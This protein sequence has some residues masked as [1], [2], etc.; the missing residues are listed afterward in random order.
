MSQRY[1][2]QNLLRVSLGRRLFAMFYDSLIILSIWL[3]ITSVYHAVVHCWIQKLT[4]PPIG[5]DPWLASILFMSTFFYMACYW[6]K[7]GQTLGMQAWKI[8]IQHQNGDLLN[9]FQCL[10]RFM[11]SLVSLGIMGLGFFWILWTVERQSWHDQWTQSEVVLL[12]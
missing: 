3:I 12:P 7:T 10:A 1:H 11:L 2:T 6:R 5:Y 8:R 4:E 9:W